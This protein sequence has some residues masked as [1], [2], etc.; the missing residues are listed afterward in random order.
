M[1]LTRRQ[2]EVLKLMAA[3]W[4]AWAP[5]DRYIAYLVTSEQAAMK[6]KPRTRCGGQRIEK[7][8]VITLEDLEQLGLVTSSQEVSLVYKVPG[9][10][11][12]RLVEEEQ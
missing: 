2:R 3:G 10:I 5:R 11:T 7:V 6:P 12:W 4:V 8:R 9:D 1:K